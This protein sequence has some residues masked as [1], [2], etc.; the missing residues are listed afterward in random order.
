MHRR[1][2]VYRLAAAAPAAALHAAQTAPSDAVRLGFIGIGIRGTQLMNAFREVSGVK[3]VAA[4]DLY[5]GC[6]TR[7]GETDPGIATGKD[8]RALLDRKD[9]DAVVIA[10]PDHHHHRMALD[11]LAAGKHIYLEK[12]MAW[13]ID[14]CRDL[15]QASQR[16]P[17]QKFQTGS[18]AGYSPFTDAARE[19]IQS[20]ALGKVNQIR[21]E[22]HRNSPGGAWV[23]PVPPDASPE[24]IDWP[25][26]LGSTP[27]KAF[28][29]KIFFR[30]R[31]WW[32]YSGGV[33]TDLFVH[34]LS[35]LHGMMSVDQPTSVVAQG[36]LYKWTDGRTV[37]DLLQA[38]YEYP[39]FLATLHVNLGNG[40]GTGATNVIHGTEGTI[41]IEGR[42]KMIYYPERIEEDV[43]SYGTLQ[44]PKAMRARYF[45]EHG[46]TAEGQPKQPAPE[47]KPE[48]VI[49]IAQ[50]PSAQ[51]A[52]I[53]AIRQG[54]P[55]AESAAHGC[56]AASAAHLANDS[57]RKGR[58]LSLT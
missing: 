53:N 6:L 11:A 15:L 24:S 41:I 52:F 38:V 47:P 7:A 10:T 54:T 3:F 58:R 1:A 20:G 35:L 39:G 46:W 12:P 2:F 4:A 14:Q 56:H 27:K 57:F 29:P 5:D 17:N 8:Y 45:E 25:R 13:S 33:A 28:D 42:G 18:A 23:Y 40:R 36:G 31:C 49:E 55:V 51:A 37:P 16:H 19:L 32:E 30:W 44:W 22:N 21:M 26:F 43:Q 50:K 48:R 34:Q 9:I